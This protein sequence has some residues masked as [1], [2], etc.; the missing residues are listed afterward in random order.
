MRPPHDDVARGSDAV[1]SLMIVCD[2]PGN[3]KV[4]SSVVDASLCAGFRRFLVHGSGRVFDGTAQGVQI[5]Q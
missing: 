3:R 4:Y 1:T 2:L 5:V